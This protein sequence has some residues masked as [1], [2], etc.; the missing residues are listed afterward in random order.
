MKNILITGGA[1]GLG[2]LLSQ[3]LAT[4]GHRIFVAIDQPEGKNIIIAHYLTQWAKEHEVQLHVLDMDISTCQS[5]KNAVKQMALMTSSNIDVVINNASCGFTGL[6]ES[7]AVSQTE[8]MFQINV[9]GT[10]RIM[11]TILPYMYK[12]HEGVFIN[13]TG[14]IARHPLPMHGTLAA[15][16]AAADALAMSYHYELRGSGIDVVIVQP[17]IWHSPSMY[18]EQLIGENLIDGNRDMSHAESLLEI[19]GSQRFRSHFMPVN[20]AGAINQIIDTP[21]GFRSLWTVVGAVGR[22]QSIRH[23]NQATRELTDT[24]L[25]AAGVE[26]DEIYANPKLASEH[27]RLIEIYPR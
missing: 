6:N 3:S 13:I 15:T 21:A 24:I 8:H 19:F 5:V 2:K 4:K 23:I 25:L 12:R 10:D 27:A 17:G 1:S 14:T 16:K 20:V 26:D 22:D 11:K 9:I 7:L 18:C